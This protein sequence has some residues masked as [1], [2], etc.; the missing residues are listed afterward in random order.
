MHG[1]NIIP[2]YLRVLIISRRLYGEKPL[3]AQLAGTVPDGL[4]KILLFGYLTYSGHSF[5]IFHVQYFP[6]GYTSF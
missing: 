5:V 6:L 3:K 1:E 4:M 2:G